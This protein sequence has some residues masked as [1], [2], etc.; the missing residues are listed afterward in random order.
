MHSH[1][2][3]D[4]M[5]KPVYAPRQ[6]H[7][8][9]Q[10]VVSLAHL[11]LVLEELTE[12]DI[13]YERPRESLELDLALI[14][15]PGYPD[16]C[17]DSAERASPIDTLLAE[18]RATFRDRYHGWVP[19]M[20]KNRMLI[21]V[22]D[23]ISG[24][25]SP[26]ARLSGTNGAAN[27][28]AGGRKAAPGAGARVGVLDTGL[29]P[30]SWL[31]GS[32]L[33]PSESL[34]D[35]QSE[36]PFPYAAGHSTF[37][38]GLILRHAPGATLVVRQ[39]LDPEASAESWEVAEA[40]VQHSLGGVDVINASFGSFTDDDQPPLVLETALRKVGPS[41]VVVAAA[42]N[43]GRTDGAVSGGSGRPMWPAACEHVVGVGAATTDGTRADFSPDAPWVDLL[44]PGVDVES[45]YFDRRVRVTAPDGAT[46][47]F[48][49]VAAWSG[50]SFAAAW[51]SGLIA[52]HMDGHTDA[53]RALA[54]VRAQAART[55]TSVW[56]AGA[57]RTDPADREVVS[58]HG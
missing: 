51:V 4:K 57:R 3:E 15:L 35:V 54:K 38:S 34:L 21:K 28:I 29:F 23:V 56:L 9:N 30:N 6:P 58:A 31:A 39:V 53:P 47:H 20:G 44:A 19:T 43:H 12:R 37:V 26:Q 49:G 1:T 52:S 14:T 24:G 33:A 55:G 22:T 42:G 18:L 45:T 48:D 50:T 16:G 17:E 11:G 25:G 10:I 41:V 7:R 40:L 32:Y 5:G 27:W 13:T 36:T 46:R 8:L 2:S